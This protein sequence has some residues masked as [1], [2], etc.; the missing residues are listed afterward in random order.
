MD[1]V[2]RRRRWIIHRKLEGWKIKDIANALRV[3]EKTVDRWCSIH[4]K[5]GWE[6]L[7]VKSRKPHRHYRTPQSTVNLILELRRN[8]HWGPCKIEGYLRNYRV[9]NITPVSHRTIHRILVQARLNNPI[10]TPRRTWG[11]HRFQREHSNSLWQA[12]YKLTQNDEWMI[13][14]LDDH[15][16][17]IP[18]SKIH[19]NPTTIHAIKTP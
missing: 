11:K 7:T 17:F 8:K 15:S 3:N 14:Y 1:H 16:R 9:E 12:D 13:S 4:R 18:G 5:S 19:H 2:L 10:Q 6:G